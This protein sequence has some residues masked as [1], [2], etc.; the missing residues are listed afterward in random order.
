MSSLSLGRIHAVVLAGGLGTRIRHLVPDVPK[1][2]VAV[3]GRPFLEWVVRHL[4]AN[5]IRRITV[6]AG[7]RGDQVARYCTTRPVPGVEL[8]CVIEPV[9]LGTAGGFCF[10]AR[11]CPTHP[12]GWLVLNGDSL[13]LTPLAPLVAALSAP[14]AWGSLVGV[15]VEDASRFGTLRTDERGLLLGFEE[16]RPGSGLISAGIYLLRPEAL[17]LFPHKTPLSFE[18]E[19]FPA[20]IQQRAWLTVCVSTAPFLD[21]GTPESLSQAEAF[22]REHEREWLS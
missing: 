17:R 18:T 20:M 4:A 15:R 10:A 1:A 16:K 5:G 6:S 7:H 9:A 8:D 14:G 12:A 13:V 21:I 2:L 11:A 22:V 19:V 3:Q